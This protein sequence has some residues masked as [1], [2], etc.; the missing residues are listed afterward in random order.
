MAADNQDSSSEQNLPEQSGQLEQLAK[1]TGELAHEIKNP[2][3]TIKVNLKLIAEELS[4]VDSDGAGGES[5]QRLVRAQRK[6]GVIQQEADRLEKILDGFLRYVG[7]TELDLARTDINELVDQVIDFYSPQ[8]QGH[9][10]TLRQELCESPLVCKVDPAMLKQVILNLF[11]NAQQAIEG[12]G[13]L[14][15]RTDKSDS[16]AQIIISDT[17]P[18]IRP[19][20]LE[21]IF[22]PFFSSRSGGTGLGL[23]TAKRIVEAHGGRI[24]VT[25]DAGKGT[26]FVI[27]LP[28]SQSQ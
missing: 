11:I 1:L 28:L 2:L 26:A 25:S 20:K 24:S 14:I 7:R 9:S 12:G 23:P 15:V 5:D 19:D 18:G 10:I 6:L 13:E 27:E 3:S 4:S 21:R 17:G 22:E 16:N 8:A